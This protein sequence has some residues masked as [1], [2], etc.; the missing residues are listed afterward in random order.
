MKRT[1]DVVTVI[2]RKTEIKKAPEI[3]EVPAL[4][5]MANLVECDAAKFKLGSM[6]SVLLNWINRPNMPAYWVDSAS[7][8]L[9]KI[10]DALRGIEASRTTFIRS[11]RPA[12]AQKKRRELSFEDLSWVSYPKWAETDQQRQYIEHSEVDKALVKNAL[13][14]A[15]RAALAAN[16]DEV[17]DA[18]EAVHEGYLDPLFFEA[19]EAAE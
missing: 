10:E 11:G 5:E 18:I 17:L 14:A 7:V 9:A 19:R 15:I 16:C 4:S 12:P 3:P 6:K 13:R 8:A 1:V 2:K